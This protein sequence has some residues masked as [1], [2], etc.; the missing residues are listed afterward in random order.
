MPLIKR[1]HAT[2]KAYIHDWL[3]PDLPF[4]LFIVLACAGFVVAYRGGGR[5]GLGLFYASLGLA[6]L[7]KD[8]LGAIGPLIVVAL[9]VWLTRGRPYG[10]WSPSAT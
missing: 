2:A 8:V 7:T 3:E 5:W 10:A 4:I 1:K 9:F 6:A